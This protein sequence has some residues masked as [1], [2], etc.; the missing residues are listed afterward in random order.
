MAEKSALEKLKEQLICSICLDI[1]SS[2]KL[3]QCFHAY[4]QSCLE[5]LVVRD[6]G[7]AIVICPTC[8]HVT[9]IQG[10]G[11]EELK[12]A[13]HINPLVEI[14]NDHESSIANPSTKDKI[15]E[16][17]SNPASQIPQ[18]ITAASCSEHENYKVELYCKSC[19]ELI[20]LKCAIKGNKHHS[21]NYEDLSVTFERQKGEVASILEPIKNHVEVIKGAVTKVEMR[22][23]D[24]TDQHEVIKSNIQKKVKQLQESLHAR[25]EELI[26][27]LDEITLTKLKGLAIQKDQLETTQAQLNSCLHYMSENLEKGSEGDVVMVRKRIVRRAMELS[28]AFQPEMLKPNTE[29][30]MIFLAP[31][32]F[33]TDYGQVSTVSSPDPSKCYATGRGIESATVGEPST[34]V[35]RILNFNSQPCKDP[36]SLE[37]ELLSEISGALA[38]GGADRKGHSQYVISYQPT[39]K[40]RHFLSIMVNSRHIRGSPFS[41]SS[42]LSV[43]KAVFPIRTISNV[44]QPV[45]VAL[46]KDGEF[47]VTEGNGHCVSVFKPNGEKIRSFGTHGSGEG[48]FK[49]PSGVAVDRKGNIFVAD[50]A[51][52]RIQIFT[53]EGHFLT[54]IGT[55]GSG[56]LQFYYPEGIAFNANKTKLYVVDGNEHVQILNSDLSYLHTFGR[57]G[58]GDGKL[59]YPRHVAC[60]SSGNVYVSDFKNHRIQVF[61][62]KGVFLRLFGN[63]GKD[64][65]GMNRPCGVAIGSN[66]RVYVCQNDGDQV[67]VYSS[68][69][70]FVT[71]FGGGGEELGQFRG[72]T[73]LAVDHSGVVY[74]CDYFNKRVQMF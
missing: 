3:L 2:P 60:D 44:N 4:C 24:V 61:T 14:V 25:Q 55:E 12:T 45:G 28:N 70:Q 54:T 53:A 48:Q 30:N 46:T 7:E 37:F 6:Q 50:R 32:D 15:S 67:I 11:V 39:I 9:P 21:H 51:N 27:Q 65:G 52:H 68:E 66:D 23:K 38:K 41:V 69:G 19:E 5:K 62:D 56:P 72:P 58:R 1:Y 35:I 26:S 22:F 59:N 71:S 29:A 57:K 13:F 16:A 49:S 42:K 40:G 47:V 33:T 64:N 43:R 34:A 31:V 8:R 10:Q 74:V 63:Y 36:L 18:E 20:C 17:S 73:G